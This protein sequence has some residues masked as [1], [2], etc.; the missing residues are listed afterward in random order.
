MANGDFCDFDKYVVTS[1]DLTSDTETVV[2]FV[3]G[4]GST[5]GGGNGGEVRKRIPEHEDFKIIGYK[6]NKKSNQCII[7]SEAQLR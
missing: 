3:N 5:G 7:K 2:N 1:V 4:V 6:L